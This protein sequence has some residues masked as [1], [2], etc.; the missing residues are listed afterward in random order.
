VFRGLPSEVFTAGPSATI[1]LE[2]FALDASPEIMHSGMASD[3]ATA[4]SSAW[5][6]ATLPSTS[7]VP[8]G[9]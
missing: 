6:A 4:R 2:K 8:A 9:N 7:T 5:I 1:V 3:A